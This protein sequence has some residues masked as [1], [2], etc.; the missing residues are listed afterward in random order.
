MPAA[1]LSSLQRKL[2][3]LA[4]LRQADLFVREVGMALK[5]AG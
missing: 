1:E 4:F 5:R 3:R 2:P